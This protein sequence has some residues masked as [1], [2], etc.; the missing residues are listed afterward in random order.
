ML[1][2][3]LNLII[4]KSPR[5]DFQISLSSK[6]K[7]TLEIRFLFLILGRPVGIHKVGVSIGW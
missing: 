2:V 5:T 6:K 1:L 3:I 4:T 7:E